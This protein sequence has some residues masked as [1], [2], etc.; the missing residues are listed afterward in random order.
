LSSC[1]SA[2]RHEERNCQQILGDLEL[3]VLSLNDTVETVFTQVNGLRDGL[4]IKRDKLS[5]KVLS[6]N[7]LENDEEI[8][9]QYS[10]HSNGKV[11]LMRE[12]FHGKEVNWKM[13]FDES[14]KIQQA[15]YGHDQYD[16][17]EMGAKLNYID[18]KLDTKT[19]MGVVKSFENHNVIFEVLYPEVPD[20]I[21]FFLLDREYDIIWSEKCIGIRVVLSENTI[22]KLMPTLILTQVFVT[23]N[24]EPLQDQ[25]YL[26]YSEM[27]PPLFTAPEVVIPKYLA[28]ARFK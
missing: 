14:G 22:S 25:S 17:S 5:K 28:K 24:G 13:R 10:F 15:I 21:Y 19:S 1:L 23:K 4:S 11:K 12:I 20:S 6:L 8:G 26:N 18:G 27:Y 7:T 2:T 16:R 9:L 3:C